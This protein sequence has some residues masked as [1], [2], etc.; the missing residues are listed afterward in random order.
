MPVFDGEVIGEGGPGDAIV[1]AETPVVP[2]AVT[3]YFINADG[4]ALSAWARPLPAGDFI[5]T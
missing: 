4:R 5:G 2:G 1:L 3:A